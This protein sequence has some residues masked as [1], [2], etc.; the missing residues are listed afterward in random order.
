M[1][2]GC[3]FCLFVWLESWYNCKCK[4][5]KSKKRDWLHTNQWENKKAVATGLPVDLHIW[6]LNCPPPVIRQ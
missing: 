6:N 3:S 5:K 2:V 1:V 4:R